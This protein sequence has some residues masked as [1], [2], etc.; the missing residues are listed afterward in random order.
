MLY[1]LSYARVRSI[2]A[3]RELAPWRGSDCRSLGTPRTEKKREGGEP[4]A[5]E[6]CPYVV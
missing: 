1:Q 5:P 4:P 2:L 3:S 6:I